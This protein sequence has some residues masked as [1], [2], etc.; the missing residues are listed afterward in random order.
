M[1]TNALSATLRHSNDVD[2]EGLATDLFKLFEK[3][4]VVISLSI[5]SDEVVSSET[6]LKFG[7]SDTLGR[8]S[9]RTT[10]LPGLKV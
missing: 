6:K 9:S 7:N 4:G 5:D 1:P 8:S 3:H 2:L 10:T